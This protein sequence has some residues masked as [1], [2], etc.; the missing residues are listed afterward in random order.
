MKLE[1]H[2]L[3]LFIALFLCLI[4]FIVKAQVKYSTQSKQAIKFYEQ[5]DTYLNSKN[6]NGAIEV[7]NKAIAEDKSFIDAYQRLGDIYR[8]LKINEK[9]RENYLQVITIFPDFAKQNYYF[10]GE[11]ELKNGNYS[12]AKKFLEKFMMYADK[13][14]Q[15]IPMA[16][17]HL[18]DSKFAID[19]KKHPVPFTPKNLGNAINTDADEYLPSLTADGKQ[20]IFTRKEHNNEDFYTSQFIND[21]WTPAV[22]LSGNINTPYLNEGAQSLSSDGQ[23]LLLTICNAPGG[24]GRCDLYYS[25]LEGSEWAAPVNIGAPVNSGAWESQPCLASDGRTLY[26][27]S[28]RKGGQGKI[29]IWKSYLQDD[30]TWTEPENL[31]PN[32]NTPY[33][34][35]SPFIHPDNETLYFS[36]NGWPGMGNSD[37]YIA[38]KNE[39]GSWSQ[40]ENVGY[41]INTN[42]DDFCLVVTGNGNKGYFSTNNTA[43]KAGHDLYSFDIPQE[44][45]P[46]NLTFIK[47]FVFDETTK[48]N[49][50]ALVEVQNLKTGKTVYRSVSNSESGQFYASLPH[51]NQYAMNVS[52]EGYLFYSGY[53]STLEANNTNVICLKAPLK[54]IAVGEKIVLKNI[55]F[56]TNSYKL[57]SESM[58]ELQKV[59]AFMKSNPKIAIE[60]SGYTDN[61]GEDQSNQVLSENRAKVVYG[62]LLRSIPNPKRFTYKGFGESQP[63]DTNETPQGKANNRRTELKITS[64]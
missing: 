4:Q 12:D 35:Q 58:I 17:K 5:S 37:I 28:D 25:R 51:G 31:G 3:K 53:F 32:I 7:L 30:G 21:Q 24:F 18:A 41:P 46:K 23:Y 9:A 61:V 8:I 20:M 48:E 27:A 19:A 42:M 13:P 1:K 55:F 40:A 54:E 29:D 6:Y 10:L 45:K 38:R 63:I 39:D 36:S 47:G 26:F 43:G 57:S 56:E 60:I 14:Q 11:I 59:I 64:I 22:K 52:R 2:K 34:E 15:F 50:D 16:K 49:L 62:Y 44:L 33:D